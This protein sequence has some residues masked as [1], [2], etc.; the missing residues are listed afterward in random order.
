MKLGSMM[1][2]DQDYIVWL[3]YLPF[4][5]SGCYP[6]H[7]NWPKLKMHQQ[8]PTGTK[9]RINFAIGDHANVSCC[10]KKIYVSVFLIFSK[11]PTSLISSICS[12]SCQTKLMPV[13]RKP[14]ICLPTG[15]LPRASVIRQ[16]H[17]PP[18][19]SHH[20]GVGSTCISFYYHLPGY[21]Q[22]PRIQNYHQSSFHSLSWLII[23]QTY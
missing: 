13:F 22:G 16:I 7:S 17:T 10:L 8:S 12:I 4:P 20:S 3:S 11:T 23:L 2:S 21:Y 14:A 15:L 6:F 1:E 18:W 9:K 5:G 19:P